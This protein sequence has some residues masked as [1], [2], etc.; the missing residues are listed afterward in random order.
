M[1]GDA[2]FNSGLHHCP[3]VIW[4]EPRTY[5]VQPAFSGFDSEIQ[6]KPSPSAAR[7]FETLTM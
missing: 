1:D 3:N 6:F 5:R 2:E 4:R 7:I